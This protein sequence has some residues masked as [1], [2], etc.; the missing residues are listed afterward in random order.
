MP[1]SSG[2]RE[3]RFSDSKY[4]NHVSQRVTL[5]DNM[6]G[7][8]PTLTN[9][10]QNMFILPRFK[11]VKRLAQDHTACHTVRIQIQACWTPKLTAKRTE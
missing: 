6:Q 9:H 2:D 5:P 4:E 3:S 10:L 1:L 8:L 11:E 7:A